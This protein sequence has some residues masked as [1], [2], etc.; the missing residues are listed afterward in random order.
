M[1]IQFILWLERKF[2]YFSVINLQCS[3]TAR[4]HNYIFRTFIIFFIF[5]VI[6]CAFIYNMLMING[7]VV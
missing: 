7:A 5:Y 3:A 1:S 6:G 4:V 2:A